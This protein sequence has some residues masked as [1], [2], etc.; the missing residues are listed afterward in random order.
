VYNYVRAQSAAGE[1]PA[2]DAPAFVVEAVERWLAQQSLAGAAAITV[3]EIPD[4]RLTLLV[5]HAESSAGDTDFVHVVVVPDRQLADT[6]PKRLRRLFEALYGGRLD[7]AIP[8]LRTELA[9]LPVESL[10]PRVLRHFATDADV[11]ALR[12]LRTGE[13][14]VAIR[15]SRPLANASRVSPRWLLPGAVGAGALALLFGVIVGAQ[16]SAHLGDRGRSGEDAS[17]PAKLAALETRVEGLSHALE[18]DAADRRLVLAR[19]ERLARDVRPGSSAR[20]EGRGALEALPETP[21]GSVRVERPVP[22]AQV[23]SGEVAEAPDAP[24]DLGADAIAAV[25]DREVE[26]PQQEAPERV[27]EPKGPEPLPNVAASPPSGYEFEYRV[28]VD[29]ARVRSEPSGDSSTRG[30]LARGTRLVALA[31]QDD[32]IEVEPPEGFSAPSWVHVSL[33]EE[34]P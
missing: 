15:P 10:A 14:R 13:S 6:P 19:V 20:S 12:W 29:T 27:A 32:W 2:D 7:R 24:P 28:V 1:T 4:P 16:M 8:A 31:H 21:R 34:R 30:L 17:L 25:S 18:E 23:A 22:P 26:T 5:L 33:V 9:R 3:A 11:E